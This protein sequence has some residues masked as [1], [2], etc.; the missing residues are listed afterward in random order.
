[1]STSPR[2]GPPVGFAALLAVTLCLYAV[3]VSTITDSRSSDAAGN[4]LSIAFAA[5]SGGLLWIAIVALLAMAAARGIMM[6]WAPWALVVL[7]PAAVVAYFLAISN[8][9]P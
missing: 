7:V 2:R 6:R 3:T 5:V 8:F 1:M 4:A 9:D